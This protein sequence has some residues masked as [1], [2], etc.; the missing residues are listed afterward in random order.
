MVLVGVQGSDGR[1]YMTRTSMRG[2]ACTPL[3][4]GSDARSTSDFGELA[5]CCGVELESYAGEL[6]EVCR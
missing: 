2:C 1:E 4:Q 3:A 6:M 5:E